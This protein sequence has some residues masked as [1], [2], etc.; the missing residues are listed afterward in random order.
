MIFANSVRIDAVRG[1]AA[2]MTVD[3]TL[4]APKKGEKVYVN[5]RAVSDYAQANGK[6]TVSVPLAAVTVEVK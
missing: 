2:G 1:N 3:V 4:K 6:V 5:G